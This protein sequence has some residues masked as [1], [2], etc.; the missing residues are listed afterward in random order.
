VSLIKAGLFAGSTRQPDY[1]HKIPP[2]DHN[3]AILL[4]SRIHPGLAIDR[5]AATA[6]PPRPLHSLPTDSR[7]IL[8]P[9]RCR[10]GHRGG[11]QRGAAS[12]QT[13]WATV[14][15]T[16][17]DPPFN[18]RR[19]H[20]SFDQTV[21]SPCRSSPLRWKPFRLVIA[22]PPKRPKQVFHGSSRGSS[23]TNCLICAKATVVVLAVQI[24]LS[25]HWQ[26]GAS[27]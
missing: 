9:R 15:S 26:Q 6:N 24:Y 25:V 7:R 21:R 19:Q 1:R 5:I 4:T 23:S 3:V 22:G 20:H 13:M 16:A 14:H 10:I 8:F 12:S 11:F 17:V 2:L 18:S 27:G